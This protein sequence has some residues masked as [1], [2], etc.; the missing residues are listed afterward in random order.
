[1]TTQFEINT[2]VDAIDWD[3]AADR[4]AD[5]TDLPNAA[6]RRSL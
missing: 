2:I 1:M 5:P 3:A 6:D 4:P